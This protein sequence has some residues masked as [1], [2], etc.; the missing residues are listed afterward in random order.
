MVSEETH[1]GQNQSSQTGGA[2]QDDVERY[3]SSHLTERKHG[4]KSLRSMGTAAKEGLSSQRW[5]KKGKRK[6]K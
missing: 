5:E 2:V 3:G 6:Q 1:L 4:G